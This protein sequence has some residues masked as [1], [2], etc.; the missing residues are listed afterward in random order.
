MRQKLL[1]SDALIEKDGYLEFTE[2]TVFNSVSAASS[3]ILGRQSPG[4]LQ[5]INQ[6][7]RTFKE[8]QLTVFANGE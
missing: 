3:V 2:D 5:W 6:D 4:P 1:D 8:V 7:G